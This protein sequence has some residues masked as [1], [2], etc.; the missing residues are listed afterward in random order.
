MP[1]STG[2][3]AAPA[4]TVAPQAPKAVARSRPWNVVE[5]IDNVV[6]SIS[7]APMPSMIASPTIRLGMSHESAAS[8]EPAPNSAAPMMKIRRWP[9]TSA[10][11][12]PMMSRLAKVS[13]YPVIT[14]STAGSVVSKSRRMVGI[15]T[16]STELSSTT[17]SAATTTTASVIQRR[18]SGV[19]VTR[20]RGLPAVDHELGTRRVRVV[21]GHEPQHELR[22][23][24]RLR[25]AL[26]RDADRRRQAV[27]V[28]A[29]HHR[30]VD[31]ARM[32]RVD[33]DPVGPE[34]D[35]RALRHA[36]HRPLG[37]R[38]G[39]AR[40]GAAE[41]ADRRDVDDRARALLLHLRGDGLH[42]EEHAGLVDRDDLVPGLE[43]RVDHALPA[44]DPGVVDEDVETSVIGDDA[45]HEPVPLRGIGDVL[46]DE[47]A[48]DLGRGLLT[49]VDEHVGDDNRRALFREPR[50]F[51]CALSARPTGDDR[52]PAVQLPHHVLPVLGGPVLDRTERVCMLRR[53]GTTRW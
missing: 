31:D 53:G 1:P 6:G 46:L 21:V 45:P 38:V 41:P 43:R 19:A 50:R 42:A 11:R 22:D 29:A 7:E 47:R 48:T 3:S 4:P 16:V 24:V 2:P 51:R 44:Q 39:E 10:S 15:A 35:C 26:Q 12:P 5:M 13:A 32:D 28:G 36:P 30:R 27:E 9:N 34:L 14:H 25:V 17:M 33:P 49:L 18:G 23:L 37:R 20:S 52:D 40:A 8:N